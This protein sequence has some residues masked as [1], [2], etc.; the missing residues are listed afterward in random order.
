MA[1]TC[2]LNTYFA[3]DTTRGQTCGRKIE[4]HPQRAHLLAGETAYMHTQASD[5]SPTA[6]YACHHHYCWSSSTQDWVTRTAFWR[7][8]NLSWASEDQASQTGRGLGDHLFQQFSNFVASG[9]FKEALCGK[10]IYKTGKKQLLWWVLGVGGGVSSACLST[11]ASPGTWGTLQAPGSFTECNMK[12]T[13][14]GYF[15]EECQKRE[16]I[17]PGSNSLW[18]G[19]RQI[20]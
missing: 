20:R 4:H 5:G 12:A 15:T 1:S 8:K 19:W 13:D 7:R 6:P 17:F 18:Q 11:A 14:P 2:L 3:Y 16:G 10:T 9:L